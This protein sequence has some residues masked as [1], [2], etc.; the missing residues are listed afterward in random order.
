MSKKNIL[1]FSSDVGSKESIFPIYNNLNLFDYN[2]IN[3]SQ[4]KNIQSKILIWQFLDR[5][6]SRNKLSPE[7]KLIKKLKKFGI[8]SITILD[9]YGFYEKR[10]IKSIQKNINSDYCSRNSMLLR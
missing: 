1:F 6:E 2:R 9:F 3:I 7:L 8:P 4:K 5:V 10:F